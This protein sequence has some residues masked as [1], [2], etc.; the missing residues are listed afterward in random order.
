MIP[1][2]EVLSSDAKKRLAVLQR[3][4]EL[5]AGFNIASHDL[6]I[7]GAGDLLGAKQ[8]GAIAAVGFETYTAMLELRE[9]VIRHCGG[10]DFW[11]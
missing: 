5:G 4:T 1:P 6:E 11:V 9:T 7:R 3:F 10:D 8:S 2:E